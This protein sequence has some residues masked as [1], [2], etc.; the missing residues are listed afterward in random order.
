MGI[1]FER[2]YGVNAGYV[3]ALHESWVADPDS[4]E[5]SWA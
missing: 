5:A 3:Q 2:E 1:D 4:V